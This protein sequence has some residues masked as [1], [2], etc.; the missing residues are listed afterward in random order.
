MRLSAN[1]RASFLSLSLIYA[2][3]AAKTTCADTLKEALAAKNLPIAGAKLANLEKNITSGAEFDDANQFVIAYYLD[4]GSGLLS[5]PLF[6][7]RFDRK[8]KEWKSGALPDPQPKPED[9]N[10]ACFGSIFDIQTAGGRLFIDT[11]INPSAGCLLVISPDFKVEASLFGWLVGR[12]GTDLLIYER[13]QPHFAPVHPTEIAVYDLRTKRD[14]TIFPPKEPTPV[15][16]A[17]VAQL[18][19]FYKPNEAWCSKND[20]PCDPEFFDSDLQGPLVTSD[21]DSALAFLISYKQIQ[22]VQGDVQKPSGPRDILY[23]YRRVDDDA[24]VQSREMTLA[25]AKTRFG[26]VPLQNLLQPEVLQKIFAEAP[27]GKL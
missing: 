21:A 20:D 15:R 4:S 1:L 27:A 24:K 25:E 22:M 7:D 19:E 2:C 17:R 12:L 14:A 26:D 9:M 23:V 16:L 10:D 18:R 11:H 5:P 8:S 13:S 6:I 3:A